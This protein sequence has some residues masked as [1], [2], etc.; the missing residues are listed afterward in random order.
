MSQVEHSDHSLWCSHFS[1]SMAISSPNVLQPDLDQPQHRPGRTA[2][3]LPKSFLVWASDGRR[4][5]ATAFLIS[6]GVSEF[7]STEAD[8][9]QH[10]SVWRDSARFSSTNKLSGEYIRWKVSQCL[11][12]GMHAFEI[13]HRAMKHPP[14]GVSYADRELVRDKPGSESF[15]GDESH[16][17]TLEL[18]LELAKSLDDEATFVVTPVAFASLRHFLFNV[19]PHVDPVPQPVDALA[20]AAEPERKRAKYVP[21]RG[22]WFSIS[23]IRLGYFINN[24]HEFPAVCK[25]AA[26]VLCPEKGVVDLPVCEMLRLSMIKLDIFPCCMSDGYWSLGN[27]Q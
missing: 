15:V 23:C 14:L 22:A 20:E 9:I 13:E 7:R 24:L 26:Q 8:F 17:L 18:P 12:L 25:A 21:A 1:T 10:T 3:F 19:Q 6:T 5:L 11:P 2:S 16:I 4:R 27:R